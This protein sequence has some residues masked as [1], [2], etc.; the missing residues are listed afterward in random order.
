MSNEAPKGPP[1][2]S[3]SPEDLLGGDPEGTEEESV[4]SGPPAA[5]EDPGPAAGPGRGYTPS[6]SPEDLASN[7]PASADPGVAAEADAVAAAR[8][9]GVKQQPLVYETYKPPSRVKPVILVLLLLGAAGF[10]GYRYY[11]SMPRTGVILSGIELPADLAEMVLETGWITGAE[12][13]QYFAHNGRVKSDYYFYTKQ[14]VGLFSTGRAGDR[15]KWIPFDSIRDMKR[16]PAAGQPP[17]TKITLEMRDGPEET[18]S[19]PGI[20]G[21][22]ELFFGGL[23]RAFDFSFIKSMN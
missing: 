2:I 21:Q 1:K 4:A 19:I 22:D 6:I 9:A 7:D 13:I 18:F 17:R 5:A 3:V 10:G 8:K 12:E 15:R 20:E 23:K 16:A 11:D 14:G